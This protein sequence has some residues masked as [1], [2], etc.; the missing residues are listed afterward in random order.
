MRWI[1]SSPRESVLR[2]EVERERP[3]RGLAVRRGRARCEPLRL[4][5]QHRVD[6]GDE[7]T[8]IEGLGQV[9]VGAHLEPDDAID[10]LAFGRE[11]DDRH[12][13]AGSTQA[14]ADRKAIL[15]GQHEVE[16][17]QV[18]GIALQLLVEVSRVGE[19]RDL[20]SLFRQIAREKIA[21]PHVVV[22]DKDLGGRTA[23]AHA[24]LDDR[25]RRARRA[26]CN[27]L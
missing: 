19:R 2:S 17:D 8:W 10:V 12:G 16:H 21:Q 14:A 18:R 15:A 11:H 24:E 9:I 7:L 27:G 23:W 4:A 1:D 22:D 6:A 13:L 3:E 5:P 25:E 20:E 26:R